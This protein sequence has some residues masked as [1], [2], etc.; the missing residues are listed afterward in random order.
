MTA[1]SKSKEIG[2]QKKKSKF[3]KQKERGMLQERLYLTLKRP[4][5]TPKSSG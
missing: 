1:K 3:E 5:I 4:G 2:L